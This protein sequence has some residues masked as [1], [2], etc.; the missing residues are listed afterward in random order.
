[1]VAAECLRGGGKRRERERE[2]R[3]LEEGGEGDG[4]KGKR[5]SACV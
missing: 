5:E 4:L 3:K 2:V 1:M